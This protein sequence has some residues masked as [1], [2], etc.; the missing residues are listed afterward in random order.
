MMCEFGVRIEGV[1]QGWQCPVCK[2]VYAPFVSECSYCGRE[3]VT[4]IGT[5]TGQPIIDWCRKTSYTSAKMPK[6]T[7]NGTGFGSVTD[8]VV[9]MDEEV[10]RKIFDWA[11]DEED[12]DG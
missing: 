8:S 1:Q 7:L 2:R 10:M 6:V 5:G 3:T 11:H 4:N 12:T 9:D